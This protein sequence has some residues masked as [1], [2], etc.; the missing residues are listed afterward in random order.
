MAR[1]SLGRHWFGWLSYSFLR[2]QRHVR[3]DRYDNTNQVM[4]RTQATVP[5]AFEQNH[6]LNAALSLRF[7][8]GYTLGTVVHFNTGRP[9]SGEVTSRSHRQETDPLGQPVWVREDRDR[10]SRLAPFVR[11]DLRAA[12]TWAL[13]DF[14]VDAYLDVLNV[15][16]QKEVLAYDYQR[17]VDVNGIAT[18]E[19]KALRLPVVLPM[20]GVKL[21]Y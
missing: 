13:D 12:K 1:R 10:V 9:E 2:S 6:V 19:R 7:D 20:L 11:V 21:S 4:E 14:T 15:S 16:F 18:L 3:V 8:S 5:F 17:N